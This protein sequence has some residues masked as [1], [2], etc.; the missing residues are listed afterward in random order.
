MP[1]GNKPLKRERVKPIVEAESVICLRCGKET[2]MKD[3]YSSTSKLFGAYKKVP[4]CK[5]CV[6]AIYKEYYYKYQ[7]AGFKDITKRAIER[8]CMLLNI[9]Y[10]DEVFAH[11]YQ[12]A[13]DKNEL[14]TTCFILLYMRHITL[15]QYH[16]KDYDTTITDRYQLAKRKAEEEGTKEFKAKQEEIALT[17]AVAD[18]DEYKNEMAKKGTEMFGTGFTND[19]YVYLCE[20][21]SDWTSRHECNS[22]AQEEVFKNICLTQLQLLEA[23]RNKEDTK[24]LSVQLQKWLDT[25]KLQPKQN[26]GEAISDAQTFGTL[27]DKWENTRPLPE[28]DDSLRDVDNIGLYIDV[29]FKGHLSRMM[30]LKNNLADLYE[31]YMARYTVNKPQ[32]NSDDDDEATFEAIFGKDLEGGE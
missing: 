17:N 28:V 30:G 4:Y 12:A 5:D 10:S 22:K 31:K 21:Y 26:S 6:A 1:S 7:K 24:D 23:V 15:Y 20:Q 25:G 11:V 27:I 9:Y 32:Y 2:K 3:L 18:F 14:K 29:F 16:D 13:K 8:V 19:E